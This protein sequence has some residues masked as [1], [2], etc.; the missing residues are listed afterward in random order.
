MDLS[1][2]SAE[3]VLQAVAECNRMG[4]ARF[5]EHY[6]FHPARSYYLSID[7]KLYDSKAIVGVAYKYQ[8]PARGPLKP[9]DFSGGQRTVK[10]LLDRLGFHVIVK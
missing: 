8:F 5:L 7:G 9:E 10:A 2:I 4:R 1:G 6:G 3:A